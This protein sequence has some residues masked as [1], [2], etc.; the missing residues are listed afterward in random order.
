[1]IQSNP[2]IEISGSV[3]Y[4]IFVEGKK[5]TEFTSNSAA[6]TYRASLPAELREMAIIKPITDN[7]Q[8]VLLG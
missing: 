6:E 8:E 5:I 7:N 4:G 2:I 3:K 1:M